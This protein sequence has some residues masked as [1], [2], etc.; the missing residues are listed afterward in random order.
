MPKFDNHEV[1]HIAE[2]GSVADVSYTEDGELI[3]TTMNIMDVPNPKGR[4]LTF[5]S[6]IKS[7]LEFRLDNGVSLNY[8]PYDHLYK[9]A[10]GDLA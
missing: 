6:A 2:D 8:D 1:L 10:E 4:G 5:S 9:P 3:K 7:V